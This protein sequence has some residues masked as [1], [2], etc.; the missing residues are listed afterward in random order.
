[1]ANYLNPIAR[2]GDFADPFVLRHDG[3]YYLYCTN[4]DVRCW[5]SRDLVDWRLE[6][7]T[8]EE[9]V[10]PGLVPFAPE[11]VYADGAFFMYTSPS[12]HGHFVLR[13]DSPT[14][15]FRPVSGNVGHAIDGNVFVDDDGRRYFYWAGDDGIWGCDMRSPAQF[16]EPVF[17]GIHMNGWTEGPLVSKRDGV[18]HMTL[19]GNHYLSTGY[20]IDAAFSDHPLRGY[21]PDPLNPIL[22]ST[23]GPVVGLGHSS[24][25]IGPDLVSTYLV[26]HNLNAD[27]SRDLNIDRQVWSGRSLQALGPTTSAPVPAAADVECDWTDRSGSEWTATIGEI[28]VDGGAGVLKGS[29]VHAVWVAARTGDAFTAELNLKAPEHVGRYGIALG[30]ALA[31][32]VDRG[33]GAVNALATGDAVLASS[34]LPVG[35]RHDALHCWR[36]EYDSGELRVHLDGRFLFVLPVSPDAKLGLGVFA[37]TGPL[38]I[39]HCAMT[40]TVPAAADRAAHKPVPGRFWAVLGQVGERAPEL[41]PAATVP[42]DA[43]RMHPGTSIAY[44]LHAQVPGPL[45]LYLA[46]EFAAGDE[47]AVKLGG[48]QLELRTAESATLLSAPIQPTGERHRLTVRGMVGSP[49]LALVTVSPAP[50]AGAVAFEDELLSGYGKRVLGTATWDDLTVTVTVTV[51]FDDDDAHAD[52]LVRASQLSEGGEGADTRLGIN[53]LLGYSVQL[54]RGRVVLARHGYDERVLAADQTLV[55]PSRPH[56]LR[57][58]ALGGSISVQLDDRHPIHVYDALPHAVGHVGIRTS[59]AHLHVERLEIVP[60]E[61]RGRWPLPRPPSPMT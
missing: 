18:Y 5:S 54:H 40:A 25:V 3:Q 19:T 45:R 59:N 48:R 22:V 52:L 7:P 10:F 29:D 60:G 26:Y 41:V 56:R 13:S 24:S 17:T 38:R 1:M 43:I 32:E 14:G 16:G 55:D 35:F 51:A 44:E 31:V 46:G 11:V 50:T 34:R 39:G 21:R 57:V 12:G 27:A 15:P 49:L 33:A 28:E 2:G 8:I 61:P 58:R 4:P 6:G 23:D 47:L 42:Y 9:D 53:F 36:M 37:A 20:R 30:E